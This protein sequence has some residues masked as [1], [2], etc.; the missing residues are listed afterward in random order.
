MRVKFTGVL[1]NEYSLIGGGPQGTLLGQIEYLI[2]S[3]DSADCVDKEDRYK[4]IDDLTILEFI[5]LSGLLVEFDCHQTV[6]SDVGVDQLYLPP[7][8]YSTQENLN[9]ISAWTDSN[10]MRINTKKSNYIIFT[11]SKANFGTR[12]TLNDQ[13]LDRVDEIKVVG[14]W[15]QSDLKWGKNTKELT[16]KAFCRV[17]MITKSK[18]AGVGREDLIDIYILFIKSV[19][20]YCA[21]V[22]HSRLTRELTDSLEMVQKPCLRVILG[23]E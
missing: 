20:E 3:N 23:D 12:L 8:S 7:H 6:P 18:Y 5:L 11:S 22:W 19:V 9:Q 17:S 14:V 2:Q 10:L 16:R 1:S 4:Y 15:L 21:V 13:L